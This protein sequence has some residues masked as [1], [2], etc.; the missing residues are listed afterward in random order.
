[1]RSSRDL[2]PEVLQL[3]S[4]AVL[5][6]IAAQHGLL[7]ER[8]RGIYSFSHL[9]F[10]EYFTARW[11][12][13]KADGDFSALI[14]HVTETQWREVFLLTVGMLK[15]ADKFLQRMKQEIDGL[16]AQDKNLQEFLGWVGRKSSSVEALYKP[17]AVRAY[18][19]DL[20][21]AFDIDIDIDIGIDRY[22]ANARAR[23]R[24]RALALALALDFDLARALEYTDLVQS[25]QQLKDR[26]PD[27]SENNHDFEHWWKANGRKWAEELRAIMIEHR[28]IGH[29]WQFSEDQEELLQQ[30]Y[31]ANEMLVDCLNS[32]CY[33]SREV[34]AEIE[35]S[36]LLPIV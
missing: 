4:E 22:L 8:A 9:T 21:S 30:Y 27:S 25:L 29:D 16:L 5:N 32:D 2:D 26:L 35:D 19:L 20:A 12:K 7:V 15:S 31:N 36:L 11:F 1:M 14:S 34:R 13:E 18:Y 28:N 23:A 6:S 33:V 3:D 10:Q 17:A 24:A